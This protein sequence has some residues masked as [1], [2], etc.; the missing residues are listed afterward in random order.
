MAPEKS[1]KQV[2]LA[3]VVGGA[4]LR[5]LIRRHGRRGRSNVMDVQA[6]NSPSMPLIQQTTCD[7]SVVVDPVDSSSTDAQPEEDTADEP[8]VGRFHYLHRLGL[9]MIGVFILWQS[10]VFARG[11]TALTNISPSLS[12]RL[13]STADGWTALASLPPSIT[14]LANCV[15][16]SF[17]D[18]ASLLAQNQDFQSLPKTALLIGSLAPCISICLLWMV[19]RSNRRENDAAGRPERPAENSESHSVAAASRAVTSADVQ[20]ICQKLGGRWIKDQDRSDSMDQAAT[21]MQLNWVIRRAVCLINGLEIAISD[22][23]FTLTVLSVIPWFKVVERYPLTGETKKHRRRD[24]RLGGAR[25]NLNLN[26]QDD[27]AELAL[28]WGKPLPGTE[29]SSFV[30]CNDQLIVTAKL[31]LG[32]KGSCVYNVVYNKIR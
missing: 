23:T 9:V 10:S 2:A 14:E 18:A 31:D 4:L 7:A 30:L 1:Q 16:E 19:V 26:A 12:E 15:L 28:Q 11:L 13:A 3:V 17:T 22:D 24:L 27:S 25:G 20:R 6:M 21:L 8:G 29:I 32:E 5:G